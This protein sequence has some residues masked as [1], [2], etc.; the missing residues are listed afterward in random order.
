MSEQN[1][2]TGIVLP[3]E[4]AAIRGDELP[5]GLD[6]PD[7]VLF[8]NLRSLYAQKKMGVIDRETAVKEKKRLL[9]EYRV[10]SFTHE[11]EKEWV[12]II[13]DTELARAEYRKNPTQENGNRLCE[14]IEG[15]KLDG[16]SMQ[17]M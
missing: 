14:I 2:G 17:Q 6:Y 4:N 12:R 1:N 15:R 11:C 9:D 13:K 10:Y 8:L 16:I 3:Y 7:Q 5:E